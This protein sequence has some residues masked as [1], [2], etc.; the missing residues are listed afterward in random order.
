MSTHQRKLFIIIVHYGDVAPL[1]R[2]LA[3][4]QSG[5]VL[6]DKIVVVDHSPR[7]QSLE[8]PNTRLVTI[9]RPSS[10]DGYG[11]GL[12]FGIGALFNDRPEKS[13]IVVG[14]NNDVVVATDALAQL[15]TWWKKNPKPALVGVVAKEGN[16]TV[17]GFGRVN[18][19]SGRAHL[20]TK[21][22]SLP[23]TSYLLPTTFYPT[24]IHGAFMAAPWELLMKVK[25]MPENYFMYWEDV[26][27]S[28]R[29]RAVGFPLRLAREVHII[30]E[31]VALKGM[32]DDKLYYLVRNGVLCLT[33]E[34]PWLWR[35]WW[36]IHT[37]LRLWYHV[38]RSKQPVVVRALR[39]AVAGIDGQQPT[40]FKSI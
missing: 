19:W 16:R 39:D 14:M 8:V 1:Q 26:A 12:N 7:P 36:R 2:C 6:P 40:D 11:A 38:Y 33:K 9:M 10:N 27:F 5:T 34:G 17:N 4:L 37:R 3:A 35:Q 31:A 23:L 24:Y 28:W 25:G 30:H 18:P 20:I 21:K 15:M 29:V 32:S 13:D 22:H